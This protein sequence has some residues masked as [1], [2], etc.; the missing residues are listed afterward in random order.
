MGLWPHILALEFVMVPVT[1]LKQQLRSWGKMNFQPLWNI[2]RWYFLPDVKCCSA[3]A[4]M[5]H[6]SG[7]LLAAAVGREHPR[8]GDNP[9]NPQFYAASLA[10]DLKT[11]IYGVAS[12]LLT[13]TATATIAEGLGV[14]GVA[15]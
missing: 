6:F 4:F 5:R 7:F 1:C 14:T 11:S 8:L 2:A 13:G 15:V 3:G 10:S 12:I 9:I